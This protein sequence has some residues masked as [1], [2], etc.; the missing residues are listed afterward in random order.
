MGK[1]ERRIQFAAVFAPDN[2]DSFET[3]AI[4]GGSGG[5]YVVRPGAAKSE[6]GRFALGSGLDQVVLEFAPLI[7]ANIGIG[8]VF[9][10]NA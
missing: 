5:C 1:L 7:A 8:E 4:A 3:E 9:A 10:F 2:A 6:Q